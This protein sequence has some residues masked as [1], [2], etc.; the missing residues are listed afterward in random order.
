[1][2]DSGDVKHGVSMSR[3][4]KE[5]REQINEVRELCLIVSVGICEQKIVNI[6]CLSNKHVLSRFHK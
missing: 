1:M 4:K 2:R 5:K 3:M 6:N